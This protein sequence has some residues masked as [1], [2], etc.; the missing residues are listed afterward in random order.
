MTIRVTWWGHATATIE[1]GGIRLL[2]D[3]LLTDRLAHLRRI[4]SPVPGP[5]ARQADAVLVSHLHLDHLHLASLGQLDPQ[6]LVVPVGAEGLV[7]S[8]GC[9]PG[10]RIEPVAP[11]TEVRVDEIGVT[12]V[13][14]Q[15]DGRRRPGSTVRGPALGYL[16]EH[17]GARIWFAGDTGLF[18]E[19]ADFGPVDLALVPVGGWGP[20]LG[21]LH[22]DPHDAAAACAAVRARHAVPIHYGTFWPLGMR[23]LPGFDGK[24]RQ[25]GA[26]FAHAVT[27]RGLATR[28]H[29]LGCGE[30]VGIDS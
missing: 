5:R 20:T 11:G 18:P 22:L 16:I 30:T 27:D 3:P 19:M 8:T 10:G 14:A 28:V 25:P 12:A 4:G 7:V 26:R 1:V 2:T 23:R 15:H 24:F 13:R 9:W 21:P 6:V 17:A 29:V